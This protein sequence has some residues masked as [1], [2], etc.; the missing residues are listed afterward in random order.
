MTIIYCLVFVT[1]FAFMAVSTNRRQNRPQNEK[2]TRTKSKS[3]LLMAVLQFGTFILIVLA[4]LG[5]AFGF[6]Y[7]GMPYAVGFAACGVSLLGLLIRILSM[8]SLGRFYSTVL[9]V[10]NEQPLITKGIYGRIRHPIYSGDL[11]LYFGMGMALGN[12][13]SLIILPTCAVLFYSIRIREEEKMLYTKYADSFLEYKRKTK[14]L[15]PF[16]V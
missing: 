7:L 6:G 9:F 3:S 5:N 15:V 16:I 10:E 11:L 12:A 1:L 2:G 13:I 14:M 4:I 8:R